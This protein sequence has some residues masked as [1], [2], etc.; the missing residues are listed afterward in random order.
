MINDALGS[1][2]PLVDPS[3]VTPATSTDPVSPFTSVSQE[4]VATDGP[5]T[6]NGTA[7]PGEID[8]KG[9]ND[10]VSGSAGGDIIHGG[11]GD[12]VISA[13]RL[14][15]GERTTTSRTGGDAPNDCEH[16]ALQALRSYLGPKDIAGVEAC[17]NAI[18]A[19]LPSPENLSTNTLLVAYGGGK[20]SS[21]MLAFVRLVQLLLLEQRGDTF[22]LR[23][24]TNRHGGM[25]SAVM[26]N[27]HTVYLR[28]GI[29]GD[30]YVEPLLVDGNEVHPFQVNRKLPAAVVERNRR[31]I[32][33]SGHR[34]QADARPT[35]CNACNLSM[36]NSFGLASWYQGGVDLIITGDSI[37]EQRSYALWVNRLAQRLGVDHTGPK[38]KRTPGFAGFLKTLDGIS[39]HYF[40]EIHG[41]DSPQL[42]D[43]RIYFNDRERG[44]EFFS[45]YRFTGYS[46]RDHWPLLTE[47]LGFQFDELAFSFSESDCANPALMAHLRGLKTQYLYART[48]EE[49]VR[50]YAEFALELMQSKDFPEIL[51]DEMKR[52]YAS[53]QAIQS[54]RRKISEFAYESFGLTESQ[55][56]AMVYSPFVCA[57]KNLE[58]YIFEQAVVLV[59]F[60]GEVRELLAGTAPTADTTDLWIADVLTRKTGL[61]LKEMR[62]C[63]RFD[64]RD[65]SSLFKTILER[66]PHK[67]LV[68]TVQSPGGAPVAE[69]IS[70]R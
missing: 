24:S 59:P 1:S 27:I 39:E 50:E 30:Q 16:S 61:S 48:Y 54:M 49:G 37:F 21:Y 43:R 64:S 29:Y 56:I 70:G 53:P 69:W 42:A 18:L 32:L 40:S 4:P 9:G 19:R 63:Y 38:S 52:R 6:I 65:G 41:R 46:A 51:I 11:A 17:L 3:P 47:F 67:K 5:D 14:S 20:D 12:D 2:A 25:P 8:A 7:G 60:L 31:D 36:M 26:N 33:L 57:G 62:D 66:D 28:L 15:I 44:P 10:Y 55:M 13:E 23:I 68:R 22:K 35:F 58:R 45:I 34:T